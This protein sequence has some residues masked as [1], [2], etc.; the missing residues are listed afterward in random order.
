[1]NGYNSSSNSNQNV[2]QEKN[3]FCTDKQNNAIGL[4][5]M[6]LNNNGIP[7]VFNCRFSNPT[8]SNP[9]RK[10]KKPT[11]FV[12]PPLNGNIIPLSAL[13]SNKWCNANNV[14]GPQL[15]PFWKRPLSVASLNNV[16]VILLIV[17]Y[18]YKRQLFS[19]R[20]I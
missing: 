13:E 10:K 16:S 19:R 14:N 12:P 9:K 20:T 2:I 18:F 7:G 6:K 1:M 17:I 8:A 5:K 4:K 15:I 11:T 3:M